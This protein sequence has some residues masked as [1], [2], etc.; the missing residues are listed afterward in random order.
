MQ[1]STNIPSRLKLSGNYSSTH[2]TSWN[3][4]IFYLRRARKAAA[5]IRSGNRFRRFKRM[6]RPPGKYTGQLP[7]GVFDQS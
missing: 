5:E 1:L 6:K 3:A 4:L 2:F 7:N